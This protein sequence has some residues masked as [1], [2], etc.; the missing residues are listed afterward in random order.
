MS[1]AMLVPI[2]SNVPNIDLLIIELFKART[3]KELT[4]I[5]TVD[6]IYYLCQKVRNEMMSE[7]VLLN[8]VITN[9]IVVLGDLHGQYFDL[10]RHFQS[11]GIP[12]DITYLFLGDYVDRGKFG[13]EVLCLLYALKVKYPRFIFI[14]R[15]D[16]ECARINR[17]NLFYHECIYKYGTLHIWNAFVSTFNVMPF[18]AIIN[19]KIFCVHGGISPLLKYV[20]Q[21]RRIERPVD[22]PKEGLLR[23][24]LWSDF[25]VEQVGFAHN[26]R[27]EVS[28]VFGVKEL[29]QFLDDN[30]LEY[31]IRGHEVVKEGFIVEGRCVTVFSACQY[32]G[33]FDNKGA[34]VCIDSDLTISFKVISPY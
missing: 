18:A 31:I 21:L 20:T 23:D 4:R 10:I 32:A 3:S 33:I 25:D 24:L 14:C 22:I 17:R 13:I 26:E 9:K 30:N 29:N 16:H 1:R 12:P 6:I 8:L 5:I 15:G 27:R 19:N 34:T 28:F 7:P 11:N 2:T